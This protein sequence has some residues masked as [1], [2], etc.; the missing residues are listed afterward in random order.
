[1]RVKQQLTWV[2]V[3]KTTCWP[4]G[5]MTDPL[6]RRELARLL[7]PDAERER[8]ALAGGLSTADMVVIGCRGAPKLG[9]REPELLPR[10]EAPELGRRSSAK[11]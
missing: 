9:R 6:P 3:W 4:E 8:A 5:V 7:R 11:G 2:L 10:S 1:M